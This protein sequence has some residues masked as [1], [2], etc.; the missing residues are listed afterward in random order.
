MLY[1]RLW[2]DILQKVC[3]F[4]ALQTIPLHK[5]RDLSVEKGLN[6]SRMLT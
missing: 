5:R 3:W 1:L 2:Y 6:D 4:I